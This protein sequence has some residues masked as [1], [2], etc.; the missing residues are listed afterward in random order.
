MTK[1]TNVQ[2]LNQN[3]NLLHNWTRE[4]SMAVLFV[5]NFVTTNSVWKFSLY[6]MK[7]LNYNQT[8]VQISGMV[9]ASKYYRM[10][11][12][13]SLLIWV[14]LKSVIFSACW[15]G[16]VCCSPQTFNLSITISNISP[17]KIIQIKSVEI[18]TLA[19]ISY[20]KRQAVPV[21]C[22]CCQDKLEGSF[23]K[24]KTFCSQKSLARKF[25]QRRWKVSPFLFSQPW[26]TYTSTSHYYFYNLIFGLG[27]SVI[28]SCLRSSYQTRVFIS[29]GGER[30]RW[31][32]CYFYDL[33]FGPEHQ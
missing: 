28:L 7:N 11:L 16:S 17:K 23:V 24:C 20:V 13:R 22:L 27:T 31:S 3:G 12:E 5:A 21:I 15:R 30:S 19:V 14:H 4:V 33:I 25:L 6:P 18:K 8:R 10:S 9:L 1:C 32:P 26:L 29:R 2:I